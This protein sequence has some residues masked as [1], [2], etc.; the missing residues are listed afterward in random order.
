M[1]KKYHNDCRQSRSLCR[2]DS[3]LL[4]GSCHN[5]GANNDCLLLYGQWVFDSTSTGNC[6][7]TSAVS[8][9]SLSPLS[10]TALPLPYSPA[11]PPQPQ[12]RQGT[13]HSTG[14]CCCQSTQDRSSMLAASHCFIDPPHFQTAASNPSLK[15]YN[16]GL[17]EFKNVTEVRICLFIKV[18]IF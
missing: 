3:V 17:P 10:P 2:S 14:L 18:P 16:T 11:H 1:R 12:F 15:P 7:S 4:G 13:T 9:Q 6:S 5:A 8:L